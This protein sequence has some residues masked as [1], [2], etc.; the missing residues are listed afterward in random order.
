MTKAFQFDSIEDLELFQGN[1]VNTTLGEFI[2]KTW[3]PVIDYSDGQMQM[4]D[5][6]ASF[7]AC[8][9]ESVIKSDKLRVNI[10]LSGEK[11]GMCE[12]SKDE[13]NEGATDIITKID[14]DMYKDIFLK[15]IKHH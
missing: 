15:L 8:Y 10:V 11:V 5:P 3:Q 7:I 13:K 9:P 6:L 1:K 14:F 12:V 4:A 2:K